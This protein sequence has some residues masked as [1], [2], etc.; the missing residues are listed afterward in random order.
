MVNVAEEGSQDPNDLLHRVPGHL[1]T[2]DQDMSLD[3]L[4]PQRTQRLPG[5]DR[6]A[7]EISD[8]MS[9]VLTRR[10]GQAA[11]LQQ[12]AGVVAA[13]RGESVVGRFRAEAPPGE[14]ISTVGPPGGR[15][16]KQ[17]R[18]WGAFRS[19]GVLKLDGR[20]GLNPPLGRQSRHHEGEPAKVPVTDKC[21]IALGLQPVGKVQQ[22]PAA[23][24][25]SNPITGTGAQVHGHGVLQ[26]WVESATLRAGQKYGE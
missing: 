18:A 20:I 6:P 12:K 13:Q 22:L 15:K 14:Q 11:H 3:V 19:E 8:L 10:L 26:L 5:P 17:A 21:G 9:M 1:A 16:P 23:R 4:A 24:R 25:A 2:A 7:Q